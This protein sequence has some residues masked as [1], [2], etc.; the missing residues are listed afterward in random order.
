MYL[1]TQ[2]YFSILTIELSFSCK[3]VE[4]Y[5]FCFVGTERETTCFSHVSKKNKFFM[6]SEVHSKFLMDGPYPLLCPH[7]TGNQ[8]TTRSNNFQQQE[9]DSRK[10]CSFTLVLLLLKLHGITLFTIPPD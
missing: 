2:K 7:T 8:I 5:L 10:I 1:V 9:N 3:I 4:T 6:V